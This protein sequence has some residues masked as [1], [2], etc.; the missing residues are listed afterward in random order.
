MDLR[1]FLKEYEWCYGSES[2]GYNVHLL[3]HL[4]D[5]VRSH[6]PLHSFSGFSFESYM[7]QIQKSVHNGYAVTK[8]AAQL[9]VEKMSFCIRLQV[10]RLTSTTPIAAKEVCNKQMAMVTR[11]MD[12]DPKTSMR[13]VLSYLMTPEVASNFTLLGTSEMPILRLH[14][15]LPISII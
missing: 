14:T 7:R 5:D 2:L 9:Y 15:K 1:N 3:Q 12:N 13:Y 4:P 8:Q 6:G 10:S 11:L